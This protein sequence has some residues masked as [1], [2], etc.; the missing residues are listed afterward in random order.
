MDWNLTTDLSTT[1]RKKGWYGKGATRISW[2]RGGAA[3]LADLVIEVARELDTKGH[4]WEVR[5]TGAPTRAGTPNDSR[6]CHSFALWEQK[7]ASK[8]SKSKVWRVDDYLGMNQTSLALDDWMRVRDD[9]P[10]ADLVVLDDAAL[11]FRRYGD[12]LLPVALTASGR[13]PWVLYKASG[14]LLRGNLWKRIISNHLQRLIVQVNVEDL[15]RLDARAENGASTPYNHNELQISRELSWEAAVQDLIWELTYN[16]TVRDLTVAPPSLSVLALRAPCWSNV[17]SLACRDSLAASYVLLFDRCHIEGSWEDQFEGRMIGNHTCLV[18]GLARQIM[19][20]PQNPDLET[21][22][23]DGIRALREL[24]KM[25]YKVDS[26]SGGQQLRFPLSDI[27]GKLAESSSAPLARVEIDPSVV[28]GS[29]EA[30]AANT[31]VS[32]QCYW[33]ILQMSSAAATAS[34]D[35][36]RL[37]LH[38]LEAISRQI[39]LKGVEAALPDVP[40]GKFGKLITVDRQEIEGYRSIRLLM[41]EYCRKEK[42]DGPLSLAVFGAPGAGKSFGIKQLAAAVSEQIKE[43]TFNLSQFNSEDDLKGAFHQVRDS[44]LKGNIPL[45]FWDEFDASFQGA[46]LGWLRFFLAPMQDGTFQDGQVTHPIGRCIFVFAG[47]TCHSLDEFRQESTG[48][49]ASDNEGAREK[50]EAERLAKKPDFI[51]RLK[52]FINMMGPN[53]ARCSGEEYTAAVVKDR[54]YIVRRAVMLRA[55]FERFTPN[56]FRNDELQIDRGVL[57]AMLLV[58]EY[59]HG[60]RSIQSIIE[61]SA[62]SSAS[63]F[64]RSSLPPESQLSLHV[65][66]DFMHLLQEVELSEEQLLAN[67]ARAVHEAYCRR[68]QRDGYRYGPVTDAANKILDNLLD[69]DDPRLN[70]RYREES[71]QNAL[72]IPRKLSLLGYRYRHAR[73][74][75]SYFHFTAD[76]IER[77]AAE[78]HLRYMKGRLREDWRWAEHTNREQKE[79][80]TL[81]LWMDMSDA[82]MEK[83]F[84]PEFT[85]KEVKDMLAQHTIGP[86]VL[87]ETH[88]VIDRDL[89]AEIPAI[90]ARAGCRIE[91]LP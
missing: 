32:R 73:S 60:A 86:G 11:Y 10:D 14:S 46:P 50:A 66:E 89:V 6:Y 30:A 74:G 4:R 61:M 91:K 84:A 16:P 56:L 24:R 81:L 19:L 57:R 20:N 26:S 13:T 48:D 54:Y 72:D 39:V 76:E 40:L 70:D 45:V 82:E 38:P 83:A 18:A 63:H 77:L 55:L 21:G 34:G 42:P 52:G 90:L 33:T 49:T 31:P 41:E 23:Q 35:P 17:I 47:G 78:E 65:T 51:S 3:L 28:C 37:G 59:H 29:D 15:R 88:K 69:Y 67:L 62:L 58:R 2:Q 75:M 27:A 12:D 87:P 79:N 71:R 22:V 44:A 85:L 9:T 36:A 1:I 80:E 8:A 25:G 64:D 7:A 5:Q 53:P 68:R 43:I